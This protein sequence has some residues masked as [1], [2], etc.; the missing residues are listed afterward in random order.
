VR[1]AMKK[2]TLQECIKFMRTGTLKDK[3]KRKVRKK[4]VK[5]E[6]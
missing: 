1:E 5:K 4:K 3:P 2:A 6:E